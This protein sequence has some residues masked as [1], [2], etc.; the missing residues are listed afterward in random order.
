MSIK[1]AILGILSWKPSTGY[2]LKKIFKDSTFMYWSGNNNQIYKAL[3]QLQDKGFVSSE[4]FHQDGAPSKKTYKITDEGLNELK[5]WTMSSPEAPELKKTFL[6]QLA[7]SNVLSNQELNGLLTSYEEELKIQ[8]VIEQEKRRRARYTPNRD[9]REAFIWD[10]IY[11]NIIFSYKNEL[12]W[13]QE[14]REKLFENQVRKEKEKLKYEV[15]EKN[16]K[17]YIDFMSAA[18]PL[19]TE[20]DALELVALCGEKDTNLLMLHHNTLSEDFYKLKT[21][22]A[23]N[24]I[25][26][27][28]NYNVKVAAIIPNS[29]SQKGKFKEMALEINKSNSFR[30]YDNKKEAEEWLLK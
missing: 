18:T 4:V 17:R 20:D 29:I 12:D 13:I 28:I 19:K 10:M 26:K 11:K 21:K 9:D 25:Q 3:V 7:W 23:G 2:E 27:F 16:H 1:F 30:V 6:I 5:E 15:I 22:V 14:L 24:I 8:L